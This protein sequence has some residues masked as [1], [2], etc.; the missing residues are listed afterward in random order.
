ML[1]YFQWFCFVI[2]AVV[3]VTYTFG[4]IVYVFLSQ[5]RH[6]N[7]SLVPLIGGG[8]GFISC[9]ISPVQCAKSFWYVPLILDPGT[10]YLLLGAIVEIIRKKSKH[11]PKTGRDGT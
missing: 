11:L 8:L 7:Y 6:R 3:S 2:F 5:F 9:L 4:N 1:V 10:C